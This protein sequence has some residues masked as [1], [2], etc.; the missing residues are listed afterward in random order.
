MLFSSVL[1]L[2]LPWWKILADYSWL[3]Q[4]LLAKRFVELGAIKVFKLNWVGRGFS[5]IFYFHDM[6]E[7]IKC[8]LH[9]KRTILT[10]DDVDCALTLR[11]VEVT[12]ENNITCAFH[13]YLLF[14]ISC[15]SSLRE[16]WQYRKWSNS[17]LISYYGGIR[18]T[19]IRLIVIVWSK[20]ICLDLLCCTLV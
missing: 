11:N 15:I 12:L 16:I 8:M 5:N 14:W 2:L 20:F 10:A 17:T 7:A 6:Q 1:R 13:I 19:R 4:S 3:S 18:N 9:S